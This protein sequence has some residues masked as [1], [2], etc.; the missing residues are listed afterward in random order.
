MEVK[1][2]H[3]HRQAGLVERLLETRQRAEREPRVADDGKVKIGVD[4]GSPGDAGPEGANFAIRHMFSEN[5][6][7]NL[8]VIRSQV[9]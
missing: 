3:A 2:I 6:L 1:Y 7:D 5:L 8:P 9:R 4:T